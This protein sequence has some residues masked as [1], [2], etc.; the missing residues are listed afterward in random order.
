MTNAGT[1]TKQI[2]GR[3]RKRYKSMIDAIVTGA[4]N[5]VTKNISE[6]YVVGW[7]LIPAFCNMSL[8]SKTLP[9][10][11]GASLPKRR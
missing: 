7:I 4:H 2:K 1:G 8:N 3:N 11:F 5:K 9:R 6:T 10:N